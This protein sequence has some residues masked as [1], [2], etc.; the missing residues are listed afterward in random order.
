MAIRIRVLTNEETR[1]A[2]DRG[3]PVLIRVTNN[4]EGGERWAVLE[5]SYGETSAEGE[6][7][8]PVETDG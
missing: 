7:W 1:D 5:E 6:S 2:F 4:W 3:E 8:R